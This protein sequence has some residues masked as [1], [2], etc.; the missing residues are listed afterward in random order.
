M[1]SRRIRFS[2]ATVLRADADAAARSADHPVRITSC[3]MAAAIRR[4]FRNAGAAARPDSSPIVDVYD[5]AD[6]G[7]YRAAI[8]RTPAFAELRGRG[9]RPRPEGVSS[10]SSSRCRPRNPSA[11]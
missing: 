10:R 5:A 2:S 8:R 4:P 3:S 6:D 7:A 11:A 9:S 1:S